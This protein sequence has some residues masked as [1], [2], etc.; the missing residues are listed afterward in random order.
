[1]HYGI[2]HWKFGGT[3]TAKS[4]GTQEP[5]TFVPA[6]GTDQY[7]V[8][9]FATTDAQITSQTLE[10]NKLTVQYQ[11]KSST[12]KAKTTTIN[13]NIQ[14]T[15]TQAM[16]NGTN[17]TPQLTDTAGFFTQQPTITTPS[18]ISVG[19]TG[20]IVVKFPSLKFNKVGT[21]SSCAIT[22][23]YNVGGETVEFYIELN[24]AL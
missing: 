10:N 13:L 14:N 20:T 23:T 8:T 9:D 4:D 2:L 11:I 18:T 21:G 6:S 19:D 22:F 17:S 16:T 12:G 1:M 5:F 7:I 15:G 24:F 3:V